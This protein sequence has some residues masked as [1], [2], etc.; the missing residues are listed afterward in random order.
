MKGPARFR[1][2]HMP[3]AVESSEKNEIPRQTES[4]G[5]ATS[6]ISKDTESTESNSGRLVEFIQRFMNDRRKPKD[7]KEIKRQKAIRA[8]QKAKKVA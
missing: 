4:N 6:A 5:K 8:Y 2:P 3:A 7:A 1:Y